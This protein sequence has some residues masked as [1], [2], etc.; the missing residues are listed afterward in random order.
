MREPVESGSAGPSGAAELLGLLLDG[1]PRTRSELAAMSGVSRVTVAARVDAL[2]RADLL[3]YVGT[4]SSS[5]GRPP[6]QVAFNADAG[7]VLAVDL[8][9]TRATVA[10]TNLAAEV[11]TV[12]TEPMDIAQGP[13]RVLDAVLD[14]ADGLLG[15]MSPASLRGVGIGLPGAIEHTTG[16]PVS[17]P[18]MPGWDRF[19]VPEYVGRRFAV[20]VLVDNDVNILALGEHEL[21]WPDVDDLV[22]VKIAT[23]IGAGI[24]AGGVLQRG[25]QGGAGD[26]GHIWVPYNKDS[27]WPVE[28]EHILGDTASGR[29]IVAQLRSRG[30]AVAGID[31]VVTLVAAGDPVAADVV[32]QAGRE[33]GEVLAMVVNTLNPRVIV[34]GGSVARAGE[35]LLAGIR[36]IVY[37]RSIPLATQDLQIVQSRAGDQAGVL[38]AATMVIRDVLT[39]ENIAD[40]VA[41]AS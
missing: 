32:R 23:G 34:I 18:I 39:P 10:V 41:R 21:S 19:G 17:P 30:I 2:L 27:P 22:F 36:E 5:G 31:E 6:A 4:E 40:A 7:V 29:G 38:G 25:S 20:P 16:R 33:I 37:R 12:T 14:I 35:Q 28:E 13:E 24:I 1:R 3:R 9:A 26:I 15:G 11:L 8:G